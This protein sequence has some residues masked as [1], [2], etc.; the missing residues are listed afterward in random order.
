MQEPALRAPLHVAYQTELEE[1]ADRFGLERAREKLAEIRLLE[2][3]AHPLWMIGEGLGA[4]EPEAAGATSFLANLQSCLPE[5][6]E[7]TLVSPRDVTKPVPASAREEVPLIFCGTLQ[8]GS[9]HRKVLQAFVALA[10]QRERLMMVLWASPR[11]PPSA[12]TAIREEWRAKL[13]DEAIS[14]Q[15]W[16]VC[17]P[18]VPSSLEEAAQSLAAQLQQLRRK[19]IQRQLIQAHRRLTLDLRATLE[20]M[21][22]DREAIESR[23]L[24]LRFAKERIET[25]LDRALR[26]MRSHLGDEL[27]RLARPTLDLFHAEVRFLTDAALLG[28]EPFAEELARVSSIAVELGLCQAL[29]Q[30]LSR[31]VA[32]YSAEAARQIAA[33]QDLDALGPAAAGGLS[34]ELIAQLQADD[35]LPMI[36]WYDLLSQVLGPSLRQTRLGLLKEALRFASRSYVSS[37][38][39]GAIEELREPLRKKLAILA[40]AL[41]DHT[42]QILLSIFREPLEALETALGAEEKRLLSANRAAIPSTEITA[43]LRR[44]ESLGHQIQTKKAQ[45]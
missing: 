17:D 11:C 19:T 22:L 14:V 25:R 37:L 35:L 10:A 12:Q 8:Y 29:P 31:S 39:A 41:A 24:E 18:Q 23:T 26:A 3:A 20:A 15:E 7:P 28:E 43:T 16:R 4:G 33:V 38:V 32:V 2:A 44:L 36:R 34:R 21:S 40:D 45:A 13:Q 1:I 42:Q 27:P 5:G 9:A 30:I 6:V